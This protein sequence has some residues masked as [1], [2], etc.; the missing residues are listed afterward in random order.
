MH[1]LAIC[2]LMANERPYVEEWV[3]FHR[4]QGV[5]LFRVYVDRT[6]DEPPD[7]GT[8]EL[9]RSLGAEVVDWTEPGPRRQVAAF[10]DGLASLRGRATWAAFIDC[11]EFLY[12]PL[13][14]MSDW[15]ADLRTSAIAVQQTVFGSMGRLTKP[16]GLVTANYTLRATRSYA[17]HRWFKTIVRPE[18]A[19]EFHNSHMAKIP[20]GY[21][22]GDA[23]PFTTTQPGQADRIAE[24]GPRLHHY[25]LKS[26][27]EWLAKK[28]RGALSD[29]AAPG[30]VRF[31]GDYTARDANCNLVPDDTLARRED[32]IEAAIY[33][34]Q[35]LADHMAYRDMFERVAGV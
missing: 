11:D 26:R 1:T 27:E 8:A 18:C 9:L 7:D 34:A 24:T 30:F 5:T 31:T 28:A 2:T 25:M 29:G 19:V 33:A 12:H 14:R 4:L 17:E 3:A 35:S 32:E 21:V 22:L 10:N 16:A 20:V 13:G 15:I 23:D 6:R